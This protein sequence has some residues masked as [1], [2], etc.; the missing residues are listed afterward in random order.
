MEDRYNKLAN[1]LDKIDC[2]A[3]AL[4]YMLPE[5]EKI[6]ERQIKDSLNVANGTVSHLATLKMNEL[7]K[8]SKEIREIVADELW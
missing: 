4:W 6:C 7:I 3:F 1:Q 5:F 8:A 2:P